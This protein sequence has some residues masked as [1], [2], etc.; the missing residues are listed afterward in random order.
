MITY[1][2]ITQELFNFLV[3]HDCFTLKN[4]HVEYLSGLS[5]E[6]G[7]H[8]SLV[9]AGNPNNLADI[10]LSFDAW[11]VRTSNTKISGKVIKI[12]E[13]N[14]CLTLCP[15]LFQLSS[16]LTYCLECHSI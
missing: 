14:Y 15:M 9:S 7:I 2:P 1:E 10:F 5:I 11:Y 8:S 6:K 3:E 16:S 4:S 13:Y 12:G